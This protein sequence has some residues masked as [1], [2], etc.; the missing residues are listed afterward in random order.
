MRRK[1]NLPL[2]PPEPR[3]FNEQQLADRWGLSTRT[4]QNWRRMSLGPVYL[5][6]GNR[7][8]YRIEDIQRYERDALRRG[9]GE[10]LHAGGAR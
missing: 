10:P 9:S 4:L 5:K 6:L 2:P 3:A 7:V 8:S 1:L